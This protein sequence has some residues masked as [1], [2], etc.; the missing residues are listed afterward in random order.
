MKGAGMAQPKPD[1]DLLDI[2]T[3]AYWSP[4]TLN[5]QLSHV[6]PWTEQENFA[7]PDLTDQEWETFAKALHT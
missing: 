2:A 5:E 1:K 6:K 7:I 4:S 3:E